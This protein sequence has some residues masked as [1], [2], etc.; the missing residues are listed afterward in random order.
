MPAVNY[1][2][3]MN[4]FAKGNFTRKGENMKLLRLIFWQIQEGILSPVWL[5]EKTVT[6][7]AA[8]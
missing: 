7:A 5:A 3:G 2:M 4:Y 1:F 8:F 6:E